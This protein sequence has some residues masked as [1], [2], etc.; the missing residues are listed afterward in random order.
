MSYL[1]LA[2]IILNALLWSHLTVTMKDRVKRE[3]DSL[4]KLLFAVVVLIALFSYWVLIIVI[5]EGR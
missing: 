2:L 3:A 5:A 4:N 1:S